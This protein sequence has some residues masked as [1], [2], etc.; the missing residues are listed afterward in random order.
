VVGHRGCL[1]TEHRS[2]SFGVAASLG[3]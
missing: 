3:E 2:D 1:L